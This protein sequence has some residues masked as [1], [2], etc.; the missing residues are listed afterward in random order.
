MKILRLLAVLLVTMTCYAYGEQQP[1][2]PRKFSF[3]LPFFATQSDPC[4]KYPEGLCLA[5]SFPLFGCYDVALISRRGVCG[6]MTSYRFHYE[7]PGGSAIE[8][9]VLDVPEKCYGSVAV[10]GVDPGAVRLIPWE[11]DQP[12]ATKEMES[13]ARELLKDWMINAPKSVERIGDIE[14][15]PLSD[16]P[17][18]ALKAGPVTVLRFEL[19][20]QIIGW[21][22]D[23]GP[24]VLF[25]NNRLFRFDGW[26][27]DDHLVFSVNDKL[28][29][30]YILR[31]CGCGESI[32]YVY[33]LSGEV[34]TKVYQNDKLSD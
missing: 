30:T 5:D 18:K 7:V 27:T 24:V 33:D 31:C 32:S 25:L 10:V 21:K 11:D 23:I 9:T 6:G 22:K 29:F 19:N 34:P 13:R 14:N 17:P 20:D 12:P 26:C 16:S 4:P 28:H 3:G 2:P 1:E 15:N 8:A